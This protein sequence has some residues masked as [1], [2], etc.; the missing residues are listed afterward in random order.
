MRPIRVLVADDDYLN[1][2]VFEIKL[3]RRGHRCDVAEDGRRAV[4]MA[5][6]ECYNAIVLDQLMPGLTGAEAAREIRTFSGHTLLIAITGDASEIPR[7]GKA[8]FDRVFRKPLRDR[9]CIEYIES[10]T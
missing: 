1:R 10:S 5:R 2:K 9:A 7:L 4:E 6:K 8:G 3:R